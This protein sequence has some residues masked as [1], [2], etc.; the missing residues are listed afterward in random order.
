MEFVSLLDESGYYNNIESVKTM[1]SRLQSAALSFLILVVEVWLPVLC[2]P[3]EV[4]VLR[5][6]AQT[7]AVVVVVVV[8][9]AAPCG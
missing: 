9:A 7:A 3:V 5:S 6:K 2:N 4:S 1:N 8:L